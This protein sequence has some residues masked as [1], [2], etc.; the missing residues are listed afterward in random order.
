MDVLQH[1]GEAHAAAIDELR[2]A[3]A[4]QPARLLAVRRLDAEFYAVAAVTLRVHGVL[5]GV[6]DP[7]AV[8][9]MD[10]GKEH[11]HAHL[12]VRGQAEQ[13]LA[14]VVPEQQPVLRAQ[15]PGAHAGGVDGDARARLDVGQGL[16]GAPAALAFLHFGEGPAHGLGQQREVL[17]QHIV[18]GAEADHLHRVLLT[19]DAGKEDEG[20]VRRH[21][22]GDG[23][24]VGAG[25][26]G[27]NAVAEDQVEAVL[28]QCVF[29]TG[30]VEHV[31]RVDLHPAA[32]QAQQ[33][34]LGIHGAVFDDQQFKRYLG[35]QRSITGYVYGSDAASRAEVH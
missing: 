13:R 34:Q 11:L 3:V 33:G 26:A 16:F 28:V 1:A 21:A 17:L 27:Q 4:E 24:H 29:D 12:G 35:H 10:A 31:P 32:L 23:Q 30:V 2:L 20:Y 15:V 19:V 18:G 8:L 7:L 25:R 22:L 5:H 6:A 14:A 9:G